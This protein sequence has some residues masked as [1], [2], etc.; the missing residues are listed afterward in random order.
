MR[1]QLLGSGRILEPSNDYVGR[2]L[3]DQV[4][5]RTFILREPLEN[6]LGGILISGRP[7]DSQLEPPEVLRTEMVLEGT[8]AVVAAAPSCFLEA[9][10]AKR[11][12]D[13]VVQNQ[14][15][16]GVDLVVG[17]EG[18]DRP[19]RIVHE[20]VRGSQDQIAPGNAGDL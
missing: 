5:L 8:N 14:E 4:H 10:S 16:F 9:E 1:S 18:A 11:Q 19:T 6:V 17:P 7:S 2:I 3:N 13:V 15:V 20:H 12:I